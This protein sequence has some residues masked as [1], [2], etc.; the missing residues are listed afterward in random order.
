[1]IDYRAFRR[2]AK[3]NK[4]PLPRTDEMFDR[5]GDV[6]SFSK[7]NVKMEVHQIRVR[8]CDVEIII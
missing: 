1:M 8:H 5:L 6:R 7:L 3:K 4:A 2:L